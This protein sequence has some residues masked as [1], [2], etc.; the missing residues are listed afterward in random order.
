[1]E[2]LQSLPAGF[3]G[4]CQEITAFLLFGLLTAITFGS[5]DFLAGLVGRRMHPLTLVLYSQSTGAVII[6]G[7]AAAQGVTPGVP[8]L[9]WGGAAC[10]GWDSFSTIAPWLTATWA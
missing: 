4:W 9:A 8:E 6:T 5:A 3:S 7:V 10:S 1:M 2:K